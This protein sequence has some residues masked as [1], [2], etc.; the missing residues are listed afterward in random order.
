MATNVIVD[1]QIAG[2]EKMAQ[3]LDDTAKRFNKIEL[4]SKTALSELQKE[5]DNSENA[6]VA[7]NKVLEKAKASMSTLG[8]G[9][10]EFKKL[11]KE[12]RAAEIATNSLGD[13]ED[14]LKKRFRELQGDIGILLQRL[15]KMKSEGLQ[16]TAAFKSLESQIKNLEKEAGALS[17]EI[18][19]INARIKT[20]G[21][22]TRSL[23]GIV[24]GVQGVVG[25]FQ[26]A[27]GVVA[28]FGTENEDLQKT[29]VKLNALMAI[30]QGLQQAYNLT[31]AESPARVAAAAFSQNVYTA[32][33][34]T[35]T[36]A[37]KAF[38][39]ALAA[40]GVGLLV[41]GLVTLI[42]NF[43]KVKEKLSE[44]F[45]QLGNLGNGFDNLKQKV[46][47]FGRAA[48]QV[49]FDVAKV[50]VE[51]GKGQF[52]KAYDSFKD[53]GANVVKAYNK[54]VENE[55]NRQ[56]EKAANTLI[57]NEIETL[58]RRKRVL[59]AGG[60]DTYAIEKRIIDD[61][62]KLEKKGTKEYLDLLT[63]REALVAERNKKIEKDASVAVGSIA[64]FREEISKL[65]N[66]INATSPESP[67]ITGYVEK[68]KEANAELSKVE[69][70]MRIALFGEKQTEVSIKPKSSSIPLDIIANISQEDIGAANNERI[71][72]QKKENDAQRAEELQA[73]RAQAQE[74]IQ[75]ASQLG[76]QLKSISSGIFAAELQGIENR[77]STELAAIDA[78]SKSKEQKEKLKAD[79]EKKYAKEVAEVRRKQAIADKASALFSI[80]INTASAIVATIGK[81]GF[82][83][84][85]LAAIVGALGAAQAAVV[86]GTP[87]PK[88]A[89]G[90]AVRGASHSQGGVMAELE[91]D[92]YVLRKSV[93]RQI[94]IKN[95]DLLN[96]GKFVPFS[97]KI[98][99]MNG[100][101]YK[102][103]SQLVELASGRSGGASMEGLKGDISALKHEM[104]WLSKYMK[105]NRDNS[106]KANSL[107]G[108]INKGI[109]TGKSF[110]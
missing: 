33:V 109:R 101:D 106:G 104:Q 26:V 69:E 66:Q 97:Q 47:G 17:D 43:E 93:A 77:K 105:D 90:G 55:A 107:L 68:L 31:L 57:Q 38:R 41:I 84:T 56:K 4:T 87:I 63:E 85:P 35:S 72:R 62:L 37:L 58:E 34:G 88:F 10:K 51:I 102:A 49:A 13:S 22:D 28:L 82:F 3:Q 71:A 6:T 86:L 74:R 80:A 27:E 91:G 100:F 23:D 42:T 75:I 9:S 110:V 99:G 70:K 20:L 14:K 7:F 48:L 30:S 2:A 21:S 18:G 29:L 79:A 54:G 24:D 73:Y 16:G 25:A 11:E 44:V 12:V 81:T 50:F 19:D 52:A 1:F 32:V 15:S 65:E 8:E 78:S 67:M 39:I 108:S 103:I 61:K 59:E 76:E 95:L 89:K 36:G 96:A 83:G 5:L 46:S 60:K 64:F 94:G 53:I 45:P 98:L 40:T 92:E